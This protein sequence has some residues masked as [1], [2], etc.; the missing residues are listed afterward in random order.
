MIDCI[1][2]LPGRSVRRG[3]RVLGFRRQTYHSRK[4][5]N[6]PEERDDKLTELLR[7]TCSIFVAWG[8]W[9]VFYYLRNEYGLQDNHKRAYRLWKQAGLLMLTFIVSSYIYGP[10]QSALR[11]G[12]NI[13][14]SS[15]K[16][17]DR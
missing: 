11:S 13:R 6:R 5:G 7:R 15:P 10:G 1:S 12:V 17:L 2:E 16:K 8:F 3:C 9:L 4:S 14:W